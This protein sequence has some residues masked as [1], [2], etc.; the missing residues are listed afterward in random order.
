MKGVRLRKFSFRIYVDVVFNHMT[1]DWDSMVGTGGST[2]DPGSKYYPGVPFGSDDFHSTCS[3]S[4][5][6]DADNVRNCELSGLH[7]LNQVTTNHNFLIRY[8]NLCL[9]T[10]L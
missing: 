7:D 3:I 9:F 8:C 1:G 6:N 5:Y 4:D 2:A 10:E